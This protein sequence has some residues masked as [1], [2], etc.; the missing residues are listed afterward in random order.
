MIISL[1]V[2]LIKVELAY[3]LWRLTVDAAAIMEG[4]DRRGATEPV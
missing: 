4:G 3:D 1:L 2:F